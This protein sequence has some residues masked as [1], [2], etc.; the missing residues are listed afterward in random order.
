MARLSFGKR[1]IAVKLNSS[2]RKVDSLGR[3]VI[4]IE[5]RRALSIE[6]RDPVEVS[7]DGDRIVLRPQTI[8]CAICGRRNAKNKIGNKYICDECISRIKAL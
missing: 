7:L 5:I 2:I 1:G 3:V 4:P 6:I 8:N